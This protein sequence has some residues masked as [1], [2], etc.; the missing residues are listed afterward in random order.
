MYAFKPTE[1]RINKE[2]AATEPGVIQRQVGFGKF[3]AKKYV[4]ANARSAATSASSQ[5]AVL[6]AMAAKALEAYSAFIVSP[7]IK[8]TTDAIIK[9][10]RPHV[11]PMATEY[12]LIRERVSLTLYA[13]FNV[14]I[15]APTPRDADHK[16]AMIPRD[17]LKWP[18]DS[19]IPSNAWLIS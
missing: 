6:H 12:C 15:M 17:I 8:N 3:G 18:L 5:R 9:R 2:T 11:S 13:A 7:K 10:P 1:I 14:S 4:A 19:M 16:D